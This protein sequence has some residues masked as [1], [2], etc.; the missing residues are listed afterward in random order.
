MFALDLKIVLKLL[1]GIFGLFFGIV[2]LCYG[3]LL[4]KRPSR[5]QKIE[6]LFQGISYRRKLYSQPRRYFLRHSFLVHTVA[7][8]L[9]VTGIQILTTIGFPGEDGKEFNAQTT[10]D[11]LKT[12]RLQLAINGS[13]FQPFYSKHPLSFYPKSGDRVDALGQSIAKGI[14]YSPP[15]QGWNV[16]C[17]SSE[18]RA[19][20]ESDRC[21]DNT[22]YG[23]GGG[24]ILILN[25]KLARKYQGRELSDRYPR[26]AVGIDRQ[27]KKLWIVVID[28]RQPFYSEGAT[29]L[30]LTQILLD[31][32]SDRALIL[33]G[34]GSTTL[35][36]EKKGEIKLLNTPIHTRIP[37]RQRP[38]ANHLGFF[39]RPF[40]F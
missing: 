38:V 18:N 4:F 16:L 7:I 34:G 13:Y 1:G 17:F 24:Y 30:E 37:L 3:I 22:Q 14:T 20:I 25:G 33:D 27:G 36:I 29:L 15:Q 28:G 8:D 32:G 21:P 31:L 39:A 5:S 26:T 19:S 10:G 23:L 11:F 9:T 12:H 2:L 35:A 6:Q 40:E